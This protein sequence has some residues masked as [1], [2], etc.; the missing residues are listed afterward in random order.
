MR[1]TPVIGAS[2][3]VLAVLTA[4]AYY[5]PNRTVLMFF[6]FPVPVRWAVAIIGLMSLLGSMS[7]VGG[8]AHMTH[9]GGIVVALAYIR[10]YPA[11]SRWLEERRALSRQQRAREAVV[12]KARDERYFEE[13]IDPILKKVSAEGMGALTAHEKKVLFEASRKHRERFSRSRIIPFDFG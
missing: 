8:I 4:Y 5:F 2:G 3:A 7:T 13:T 11:A 10:L 9:L 1:N 12:K 6:V